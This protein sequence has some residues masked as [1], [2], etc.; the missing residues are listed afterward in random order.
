V[1]HQE[2]VALRSFKNYCMCGGFAWTM[3]G[4]PER[5]PH[6]DWCQ[7]MQEYAE[8][9]RALHVEGVC[10]SNPCDHYEAARRLAGRKRT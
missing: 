6:M 7:Q 2:A 9:W 5:Q 3:N 10:T 4:R 8:W 1:T